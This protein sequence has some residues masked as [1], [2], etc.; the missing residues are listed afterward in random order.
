MANPSDVVAKW[1]RNM[2]GS[3]PTIKAG[4]MAVT[5]SP[6]EAAAQAADRYA[7]G[8]Q[9][10]VQSGTY[11]A[12]LR[13]VSL[14]DWQDATANKGTARINA[15]VQAAQTKMTNFMNQLL[16]FTARVKQTIGAM[17]K[18]QPA[19][20]DARMLAAVNMMRQ[21]KFQRRAS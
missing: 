4:V 1:T 3:I 20:S 18:G 10:A 11:Q 9:Q 17:P 14:A 15:G 6:M 5:A 12:G 13:S 8:V 21:F 16:P 2:Q 19:D 7:A